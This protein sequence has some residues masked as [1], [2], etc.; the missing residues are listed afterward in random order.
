MKDI[1]TIMTLMPPAL[2]ASTAAGT[3][4]QKS[5]LLRYW[6]MYCAAFRRD[7]HSFGYNPRGTESEV[8]ELI[9][10]EGLVLAGLASSFSDLSTSRW[11]KSQRHIIC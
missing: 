6:A 1:D 9:R 2:D 11:S 8:R 10:N 3:K 5:A 7:M 4:R